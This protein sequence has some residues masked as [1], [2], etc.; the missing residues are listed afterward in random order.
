MKSAEAGYEWIELGPYGYLP[1]DGNE[2]ESELDNRNLRVS[3]TFIMDNFYDP[4]QWPRVE[5][6][7][8]STC[9][10]LSKLGAPFLIIIPNLYTDPKTNQLLQTTQLNKTQW[11][12]FLKTI[13]HMGKIAKETFSLQ[14]VFHPHAGT[15]VEHLSQ[16]EFFLAEVDPDTIS[17]CLD[18][19]HLVYQGGEPLHFFQKHYQRI[20]YIHLKNISQQIQKNVDTQN[21][22]FRQAVAQGIFFEPDQ[23][24]INFRTLI[25]SLK[26]KKFNGFCIVE[27]D[28]YP[29]SFEKPLPI[30]NRTKKYFHELG[31]G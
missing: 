14:T 17:I 22:P 5:R 21:L 7:F 18:T 29:V 19:G 28:M 31:I 8:F 27:Q 25:D 3:G 6:K 15:C 26:A 23:G 1:K 20:P 2:L 16:I 4:L 9:E 30:A 24:I 12:Q 13:H 11:K 10:I